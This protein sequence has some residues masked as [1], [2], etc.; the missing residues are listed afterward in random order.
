MIF[1]EVNN[2][3]DSINNN[4][5]DWY[6]PVD[7]KWNEIFERFHRETLWKVTSVV[8]GAWNATFSWTFSPYKNPLF[9]QEK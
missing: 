1:W 9:E 6:K 2:H 3:S 4:V 8:N 5:N 7:T